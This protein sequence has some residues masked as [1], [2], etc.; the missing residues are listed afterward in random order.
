MQFDFIYQNNT[1][2]NKKNLMQKNWGEEKRDREDKIC[3]QLMWYQDCMK[4]EGSKREFNTVYHF[5]VSLITFYL[6]FFEFVQEKKK[7]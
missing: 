6:I 1:Y 5:I 4:N 7:H 3:I 2:L